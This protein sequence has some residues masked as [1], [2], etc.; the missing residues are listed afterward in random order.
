VAFNV[1]LAPDATLDDAKR[2]AARIRE[3]G[4]EGLP[5]VRAL[6]LELAHGGLVQ[7]STNIEDPGRTTAGAV[8][9]AVARHA[10]VSGA[11][12]VGLAPAAAIADVEVALRNRRTF[13]EVIDS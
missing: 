9:A 2:I 4:D 1:E 11:E 5:G 12:L 13:E 10:E 6:G 3:G 7:I 8:V